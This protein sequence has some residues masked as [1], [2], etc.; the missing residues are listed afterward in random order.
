MGSSWVDF[1]G[2]K[3]QIP[4]DVLDE[5][6]TRLAQDGNA[7]DQQPSSLDVASISSKIDHTIL[8]LDAEPA[9]IDRL[10]DEAKEYSFAVMLTP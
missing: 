6:H 3:A 7:A 8:A 5:V 2:G 10:C 4:Q 1:F 9:Q